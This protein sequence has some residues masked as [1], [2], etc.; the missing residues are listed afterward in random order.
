[1]PTILEAIEVE[2]P[3]AI[4]GVSQSDIQGVSFAHTF[5]DAG[6]ASEHTTQY[7]EMF[8]HRS[9]YHDGWRAVCPFPGPSF[10][11]ALEK[12]RFFGGPLTADVLAD[13]D[14]NGWELYRLEDDPSERH[15]LAESNPAKLREL[16]E[17]WYAEAERYGVLPLATADLGRMNTERPT[18]SR[19][20]Q[21][22]VYQAGGAAIPFAASPRVYNRPH[23]I[24]ADVVCPESGADG[25]LL[26]HGNRHGGY[27]FYVKDGY[28]NHVHNYMG[29]RWFSVTSPDRIPAGKVSLRYEFEPTGELKNDKGKGTSGRSQLYVDDRLVA[30]VEIPYTVPNLFGIIGLCCGRDATDS[31]SPKDYAAPF[32]FTGQIDSV[33][34]DVTGELIEDDESEM[35]RL[36]A[37]Q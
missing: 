15:D 33:T 29:K 11:E 21:K 13:L 31:V 24:S 14:A 7:F 37:Q 34:L 28:L 23:S 5:D 32:A 25:V 19:P 4:R 2:A 20:R 30:S 17:L 10:K 26:A 22:Y 3:Q 1:V 27:S 8:G 36:M 35:K 9:L 12:G 16:I 6:A 18:I